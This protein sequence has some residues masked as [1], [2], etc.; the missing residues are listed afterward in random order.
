MIPLYIF[1]SM[2]GFSAPATISGRGD[3]WMRVRHQLPPPGARRSPARVCSTPTATH[4]CWPRRIRR[5]WPTIR[6]SRSNSGTSSP[7]VSRGC[8]GMPGEHLLLHHRLQ[9][10]DPA[11]GAAR[12]CRRRRPAQ[13][14]LSLCGGPSRQ[15]STGQHPGIRVTMPDALRAAQLRF[16]DEWDVG[17][18]VYSVTSWNELARDG[19][20]WT[21]TRSANRIGCGATVPDHHPVADRRA[22]RRRQRLRARRHRS[23]PRICARHPPRWAPTASA[24]PT[25]G[26]RPGGSS[27]STPS[28]SWWRRSWRC[29]GTVID[30]SVAAAAADKYQITDVSAAPEQ[31][32]DPGSA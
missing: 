18:A 6:R 22:V 3:R 11:A 32:S 1:Y 15:R 16:A 13:R 24:S 27:M 17:A 23:D 20:L 26:R 31:I 8:T 10:A 12:R 30:L 7:T 21:A 2:F 14:Y 19:G 4:I 9:R 25:P 28:R 29:R 5:W